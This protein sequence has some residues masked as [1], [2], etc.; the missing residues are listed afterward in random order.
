MKYQGESYEILNSSLYLNTFSV[1]LSKHV[2]II[3]GNTINVPLYCEYINKIQSKYAGRVSLCITN[4]GSFR[5]IPLFEIEKFEL[6]ERAIE[7][8]S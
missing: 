6:E 1:H 2:L 7:Y 5:L 4:T 8:A 3:D